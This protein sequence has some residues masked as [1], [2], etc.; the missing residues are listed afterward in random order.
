MSDTQ[1]T[2]SWPDF[3]GLAV[4]VTGGTGFLGSAVVEKLLNAGATCHLSAHSEKELE[5]F[6]FRNHERVKLRFPVDL[7][8]EGQVEAFYAEAPPLW[9][10]IHCAGGFAMSDLADTSLA[11]WRR[12]HAGNLDSCFL[13][14][15]E[16]VKSIRRRGSADSTEVSGGRIVNVAARP[17]LEPRQ[18]AGMAAYT[19]AKAGVAA[20]TQALGEELAAEGIW[21]N[22]VV[23]SIIDTP[24]NRSS[25]PKADFGKWPKVGELAETIVFLASPANRATRGGLVPVFGRS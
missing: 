6:P 25:M 9:A 11:D 10:S 22:A 20:L 18:G 14:C 23:P 7:A 5:R 21:V 3:T 12:Q 17:A 4:V 15:R 16:A 13:C 1:G 19:A 2:P 24:A 8:D